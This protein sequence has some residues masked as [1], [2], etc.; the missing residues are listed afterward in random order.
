[1]LKKIKEKLKHHFHEVARSRKSSHSVALGF[2]VGTFIS[3]LPT[4]GLNIILGL[5][6]ALIYEKIN[7][8]SLLISIFFWNTLTLT[9]IYILSFKI[10][11]LLFGDLP[12]VEYGIPILNKIYNFTLRYLIGNFIMAV[13]VSASSYFIIKK[14]V[15]ELRVRHIIKE[16]TEGYK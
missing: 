5:L 15:D 2:A 10:G 11:D 8:Y 14:I 4:P 6:A 12:A 13:T 1:M 3:I 9:P 16:S 7:K